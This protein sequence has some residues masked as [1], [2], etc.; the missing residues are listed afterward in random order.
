MGK[1]LSL[2]EKIIFMRK[3]GASYYEIQMELKCSKSTIS[4]HCKDL[5]VDFSTKK[6]DNDLIQEAVE[7]YKTHTLKETSSKF[8][9]SISTLKKHV[10]KKRVKLSDG[11]RKIKNYEKVK[12]HRKRMKEKSVEYKGGSCQMCGYDKCIGALEFHHID[13]TQKDF[14]I[15]SYIYLSWDKIKIELDKCILVC[16][17]CHREIHHIDD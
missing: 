1:D 13:P 12:S 16:A 10:Q 2:K 11:E 4:Y 14:G 15:S 6:I 8:N 3:N 7:Y 17:N 5:D 9:I